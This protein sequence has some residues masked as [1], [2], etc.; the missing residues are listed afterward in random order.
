MV[1]LFFRTILDFMPQTIHSTNQG[2]IIGGIFSEQENANKAVDALFALK[3]S[4]E[5]LQVIIKLNDDQAEDTYTSLL[6]GRGFSETQAF[7]HN[8]V[9]REGKVFV[10]VYEVTDPAPIIDIFNK[11]KAEYNPNGSR[12]LRN[13][14]AG[15]T[16]GAVVCA[17]A[18]GAAGAVIAGPVGAIAGASVGAVAGGG[19]GA[20]AGKA[21][22]HSK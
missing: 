19:S 2:Q 5:N 17:A 3:I 9:I 12:N 16:V 21:S 10:A 1:P 11:Y 8:K 6:V 4:P 20:V 13:D 18:G 22:E 7:Y 14:V 15:M